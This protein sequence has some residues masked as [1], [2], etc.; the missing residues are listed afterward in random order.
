MRRRGRI[1]RNAKFS[2]EADENGPVDP[3]MVVLQLA[4]I[5][6]ALW[7]ARFEPAIAKKPAFRRSRLFAGV[8]CMKIELPVTRIDQS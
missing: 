4:G 5:R 7:P 2:S 3:D 6:Q 8:P 1:K